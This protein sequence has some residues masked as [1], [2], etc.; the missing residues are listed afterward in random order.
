MWRLMLSCNNL[1]PAPS[2]CLDQL[3]MQQYIVQVFTTL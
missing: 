2:A 1:T 3:N